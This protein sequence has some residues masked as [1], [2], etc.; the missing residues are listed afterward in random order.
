[1]NGIM[2]YNKP[3]MTGKEFSELGLCASLPLLFRQ[4]QGRD[5][6]LQE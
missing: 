2:G 6:H 3:A 4:M 1:M 5:P